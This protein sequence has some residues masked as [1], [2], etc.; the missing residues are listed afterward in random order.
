MPN[1]SLCICLRDCSFVG[2]DDCYDFKEIPRF[3]KDNSKTIKKIGIVEIPYKLM[4][5][6]FDKQKEEVNTNE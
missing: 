5:A 1:C 3:E 4:K 6:Y 2:L